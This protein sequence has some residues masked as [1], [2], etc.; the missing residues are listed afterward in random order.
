MIDVVESLILDLID[1]VA[2]RDR[3]YEEVMDAWRTSCPRL[4]VW[5][6][7]NDRGL[8]ATVQVEGRSVVRATPS[9]IAW[10]HERRPP[11]DLFQEIGGSAKCLEL[12]TAFYARVAQ[13]PI[14]RPLFPGKSQR[15]AIEA[16]SAFLAQFLDGPSSDAAKRWWLSLRESHQRFQIGRKERDA[17]VDRMTKVLGDVEMSEPMR[18]ALRALFE[19]ASAYLVNTGTAVAAIERQSEP[20]ETSR[21]IGRRWEEQVALDEVVAAV[22]AGDLGRVTAMVEGPLLQS[23]FQRNRAVFAT[24]AGVL[25]GSGHGVMAEYGHRLLLENPDL[26][27]VSYSGR[28]LLHAASAAGNLPIVA[29]LLKLGVD[30]NIQDRG[31]HTPLYSVGNEC[32]G[33]G[34]V[35]RAL[36]QGGARVDACDGVKRSTAL[37][38]AARRGN[39]EAADALLE[40]GANIEAR[41]S[42]GETPLRRAVNCGKTGVAALLLAKGADP[43]SPGSKGLTPLSAARTREMRSLLESWAGR[44]GSRQLKHPS[45]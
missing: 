3:T 42:L 18:S 29:A 8:I 40:C 15:C 2:A 4:P 27:H 41:D 7:A 23:R 45:T 22:R 31:G 12:S 5:E 16:L 35:I 17:W 13:D 24:F 44:M 38:M 14:L 32:S 1:W 21:Q 9:G 26:A 25:S 10:L 37:H 28:T 30:A 19:E 33:G 6:D 36:I 20:S 11:V 39:V 34:P 43:H